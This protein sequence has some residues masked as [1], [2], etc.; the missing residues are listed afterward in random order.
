MT[1][2]VTAEQKYSPDK[3]KRMVFSFTKAELAKLI[4]FESMMEMGKTAEALV[5][6]MLN[7]ICLPRVGIKDQ[8][9]TMMVE[10][11]V[12]NGTFIVYAPRA[13][14]QPAEPNEKVE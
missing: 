3:Y 6:R 10:Y 12:S 7:V 4:S 11:D 5:N 1:N 13:V 8:G 14:K 2:T 9:A